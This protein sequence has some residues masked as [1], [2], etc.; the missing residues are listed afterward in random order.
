[1]REIGLENAFDRPR[2]IF[3]DNIAVKLPPEGRIR[4]ETAADRH[5]ITFDRIGLLGRL[6]FTGKQSD[7]GYEMLRA[8]MMAAGEMNVHGRIKCNTRLA[9]ARYFLRMTF[10][11]GCGEFAAS[12]AGARYQPR[13]N[14]VGLVSPGQGP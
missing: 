11:V 10:G 3:C 14:S 7:L 6:D 13:A 9:P 8:G 5:V 2:R 4:S 12:I 1:M